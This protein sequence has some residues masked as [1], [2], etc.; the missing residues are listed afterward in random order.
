[1]GYWF[2]N[3]VYVISAGFVARAQLPTSRAQA[4]WTGASL[5]TILS[6]FI[7]NLP[8]IPTG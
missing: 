2:F 7:G 3:I 1:M 5:P 8:P 6:T 4:M